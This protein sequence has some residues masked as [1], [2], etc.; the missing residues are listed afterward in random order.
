MRVGVLLLLM[1]AIEPWS[2]HYKVVSP[3][4]VTGRSLG[5]CLGVGGCVEVGV[6]FYLFACLSIHLS[7]LQIFI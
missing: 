1:T 6:C 7:I 2:G 3:I 4:W 5:G